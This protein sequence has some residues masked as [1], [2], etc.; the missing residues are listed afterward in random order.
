[1]EVQQVN[2]S[3]GPKKGLKRE[4]KKVPLQSKLSIST[5]TMKTCA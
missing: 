5:Y 1:M 3:F 2:G 4:R